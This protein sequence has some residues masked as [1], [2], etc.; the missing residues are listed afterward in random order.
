MLFSMKDF[1]RLSAPT[2]HL[3]WLIS[4][5]PLSHSSQEGVALGLFG[6]ASG[7]SHPRRRSAH[8]ASGHQQLLV[9]P[10]R[11]DLL[12][13]EMR[14]NKLADYSQRHFIKNLFYLS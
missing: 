9:L 10:L 14:I 4:C 6:S 13:G 8:S 11:T 2:V 12:Q 5:L 3:C 7:A 1:K